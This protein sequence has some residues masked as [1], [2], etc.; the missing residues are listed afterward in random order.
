MYFLDILRTS[1]TITRMSKIKAPRK[2]SERFQFVEIFDHSHGRDDANE[3]RA[4]FMPTAFDPENWHHQV[5]IKRD[6][7]Q[8][9]N[10]IQLTK[11]ELLKRI[12]NMYLEKFFEPDESIRA[13]K[14][15]EAMEKTKPV[16]L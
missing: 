4:I 10:S 14:E 11:D 12:E 8:T 16:Q 9:H 1:V 5:T 15:F 7:T 6:G 3:L 2:E 13:L